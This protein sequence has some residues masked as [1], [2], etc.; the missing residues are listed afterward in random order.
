MRKPAT[1]P[2]AF[3]GDAAFIEQHGD[4]I[5]QKLCDALPVGEYFTSHQ[6]AAVIAPMFPRASE[7]Q[8]RRKVTLVLRC[9]L[10][11]TDSETPAIRRFGHSWMF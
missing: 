2:T 3:D 7:A 1:I 11:E 4:N 5:W 10:V 8:L 6:A 9:V